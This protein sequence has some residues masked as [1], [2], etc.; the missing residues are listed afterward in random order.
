MEILIPL[1][2]ILFILLLI[3]TLV[4]HGIWVALAWCFREFSGRK[5]GGPPSAS[6]THSD[7]RLCFNSGYSLLIQMKFCGVCGAHRLPMAQEELIRALEG[8][9]LHVE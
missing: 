7:L 8:T 1:L 5:T 4:G 2:I 6:Y 9:L 3:V